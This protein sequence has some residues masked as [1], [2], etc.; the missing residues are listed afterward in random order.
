VS[1]VALKSHFNIA[2]R[3]VGEGEPVF[4]IAEAGVSHFGKMDLARQ[5]VQLA[6]A[7]KADAFKTQ[8]FDVDALIANSAPEWR[9]RLRPRNLS[10]DQARE[11]KLMCDSLGILFMATAHDET[12]LPWLEKLDVPAVKVGSGERNNPGFLKKLAALGKPMIVSTGMYREKDVA[13]AVE[14]CGE[15]GCDR[16]ALLHCV[17]SYPAPSDEVNLRAMDRLRE[18]F[19]GPVGYSD[20]TVDGLAVLAAV[21][22]GA[23]L[24]E[25]HITI[26]RDVPNAQDWKVSAG[27]ENFA[28][29]VSDIRRVEALIGH[30][31]KEPASCE[32][33][34]T[35]WALKSLVAVRDLPGGQVLAAADLIAKRPGDGIPPNQLEHVLGRVLKRP[36]AADEPLM[37]EHLA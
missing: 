9:E 11:L 5:L 27:P 26:L 28:G 7:A 21:A 10:F 32:A 2:D 18:I 1:D 23:R 13:E 8:F 17:T 3:A 16:L 12:R 25:K 30:G 20:H 31:R 34:G 24:I 14:A 37:L 19:P 35:K 4:I 22:R 29:L 36:L 33:A 15:G 6:A